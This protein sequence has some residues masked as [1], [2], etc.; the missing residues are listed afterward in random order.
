[1]PIE[2]EHEQHENQLAFEDDWQ[3]ND[4]R[5]SSNYSNFSEES[6]VLVA[7]FSAWKPHGHIAGHICCICCC[8][9]EP[10]PKRQI[11]FDVGPAL[12]GDGFVD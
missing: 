3:S 6:G 1:M 7:R 4:G 5:K 2:R 9:R 12:D 8:L 11:V 10:Q